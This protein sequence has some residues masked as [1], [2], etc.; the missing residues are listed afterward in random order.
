MTGSA[1]KTVRLL[2]PD[3]L[4]V[5]A[6]NAVNQ[7][8]LMQCAKHQCLDCAACSLSVLWLYGCVSKY[9]SLQRQHWF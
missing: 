2:L 3:C 6:R 7:Q 8:A 1:C 9:R 5:A 4:K